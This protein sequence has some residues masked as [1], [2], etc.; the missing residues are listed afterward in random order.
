M[1][2]NWCIV[3]KVKRILHDRNIKMTTVQTESEK[4][5]EESCD[6]EFVSTKQ[7]CYTNFNFTT[8][9]LD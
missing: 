3:E 7:N 1:K 5:K 8:I 9:D 4:V 2:T 6:E